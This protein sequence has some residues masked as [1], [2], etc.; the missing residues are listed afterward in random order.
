MPLVIEKSNGSDLVGKLRLDCEL[1]L[2]L[3]LFKIHNQ[4]TLIVAHA[5][6]TTIK[7]IVAPRK[8]LWVAN[9]GTYKIHVVM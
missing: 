7:L 9:S 8:T 2:L 5:T 3:S 6:I 1:F 4:A